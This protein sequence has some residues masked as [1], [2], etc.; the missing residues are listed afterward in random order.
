MMIEKGEVFSSYMT[1]TGRIQQSDVRHQCC[2]RMWHCTNCKE[3]FCMAEQPK[4]CPLCGIQAA[5]VKLK[6][7]EV[8]FN[9]HR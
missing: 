4:F 5:E 6:S 3:D 9:A 2:V 8:K 1:S 7:E